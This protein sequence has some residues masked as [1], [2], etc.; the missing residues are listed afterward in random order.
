MQ[1]VHAANESLKVHSNYVR[2]KSAFGDDRVF[3]ESIEGTTRR[4]QVLADGEK[5]IHFG[6]RFV[7][8]SVATETGRRRSWLTDEKRASWS[9]GLQVQNQWAT[10]V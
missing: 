6:E 10:K 1:I 5:A 2:A 4:V 7:Q 9:I 3:V 8:F